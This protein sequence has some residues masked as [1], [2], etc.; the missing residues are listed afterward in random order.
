MSHLFCT[1]ISEWKALQMSQE[2]IQKIEE[3]FEEISYPGDDN[4]GMSDTDDFIGQ[5]EW[6]SVPLELLLRNQTK[7]VVLT[8]SAYIFYLPAYMC[9]VLRYPE[10]EQFLDSI[11]FSLIPSKGYNPVSISQE[12]LSLFN[13][14]Q[15]SVI[16]EFLEKHN[17]LFPQSSYNLVPE[18]AEQLQ[19]AVRFWKEK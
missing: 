10:A 12:A 2:L 16:I 6:Q 17:V 5:K 1:N 8:P 13:E 7:I 3:A 15:K 11:I 19:Q 9:A 4:I 14:V 18:L